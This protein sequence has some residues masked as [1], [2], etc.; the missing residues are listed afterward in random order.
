MDGVTCD[1]CGRDSKGIL[2]FKEVLGV[3]P[4]NSPETVAE[5]TNPWSPCFRNKKEFCFS[6]FR[7]AVRK[8]IL[9]THE[10]FSERKL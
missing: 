10:K 8:Y 3:R 1:C 2:E 9:E 4:C 7:M 6:C 5:H